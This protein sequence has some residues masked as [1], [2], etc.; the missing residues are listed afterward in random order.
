[1][2]SFFESYFLKSSD[3][4][5]IL[6]SQGEVLRMNHK[7]QYFFEKNFE[8]S[9]SLTLE[10]SAWFQNQSEF[11]N[12]NLG[13]EAIEMEVPFKNNFKLSLR[14]QKENDGILIQILNPDSNA[15]DLKT[16]HSH[17]NVDLTLD[18]DVIFQKLFESSPIGIIVLDEKRKYIRANSAYQDMMGYHISELQDLSVFDL[19]YVEDV[20]ES[21]N[22]SSKLNQDNFKLS[23]LS[24]RMV[25]KDGR[26][27]HV[28]VSSSAF[29]DSHGQNLVVS[30]VEDVS[31]Q[32]LKEAE[33]LE[34]Q[35]TL[36]DLS[37][38]VPGVV[39]I[40]K[41]SPQGG[42]QNIYLSHAAR[43]LF[44][45]ENIYNPD[46]DWLKLV[47]SEDKFSL[48]QA[49]NDSG[50]SMGLSSWTGKIVLGENQTKWVLC[51]L[52]AKEHSKDGIRWSAVLIDITEAKLN[53]EKLQ[54]FKEILENTP[55]IVAVS[56]S[57]GERLYSNKSF[58][59]HFGEDNNLP[60]ESV[61]P[62]WAM[63]MIE[64]MAFPAATQNGFWC[65]ETA[66]INQ[67]KKE[68]PVSQTIICHRSKTGR[69]EYYSTIMRDIAEIKV[70]QNEL[71][72]I[73][74]A[75]KSASAYSVTDLQG[76]FLEVNES[77]CELSGYTREELI[78]QHGSMMVKGVQGQDHLF[79]MWKD[80]H[81]GK[82]WVGEIENYGKNGKHYF[83]QSI[84]IPI[85]NANNK[86][87]RIMLI[88]FDITRVKDMQKKLA[89]NSKI[90][91]LGEMAGGIAHEINNPLAIIAGKATMMKRAL[92]RSDIDQ[93]TL[94]KCAEDIEKTVFRISQ[95][96]KG[97]KTF[98]RDAE[99]DP[100]EWTK[101]SDIIS[102]TLAFCQ[103]RFLSHGIEVQIN[104]DNLSETLECRSA[105]I[106]QCLL[107]LLNNS[108]DAVLQQPEKWIKLQIVNTEESFQFVITDS[109]KGIDQKY[110]DKLM[111]P[112]FT[113]KEIGKGMGLGLSTASGIAKAHKGSLEFDAS[114]PNTK[115][116]LT[117]P[118]SQ[119]QNK[120]A[121]A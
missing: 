82:T 116:I 28:K 93:V 12:L 37:E 25:R 33:L 6:N 34:N 3:C 16:P 4:L 49:I 67:D 119:S 20:E 92:A 10:V 45:L 121:V 44:G 1:M 99:K 52:K 18:T 21:L 65:G 107:S 115:F 96:V 48:L 15:L 84:I 108:H 39:Q 81:R 35:K 85:F 30:I 11:K 111:Q 72:Q 55:D 66:V 83:V 78:G 7:A 59:Q 69:P 73:L 102:D 68:I 75:V 90:S 77:F 106:S 101:I 117:I 56:K 22:V 32:T 29:Q 64:Q 74:N 43:E 88:H 5:V 24:K 13:S 41:V 87:E 112:F 98:S 9:N 80:V 8:N 114:S 97:L 27:I 50:H 118:K 105:Q 2:D 94:T 36:H 47:H 58:K 40:F 19:T 109:G 31:A 54:M 79:Q 100:F 14:I 51:N 113:T 110:I 103:S 23:R 57:T 89:Y 71:H 38:N 76:N 70:T 46:F 60:R 61:H 120:K 42:I 86:L 53:E 17:K 91:S 62:D 26:L 63:L 95:V 104:S